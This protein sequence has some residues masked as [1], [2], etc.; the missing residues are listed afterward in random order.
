MRRKRLIRP[1]FG[2]GCVGLIRRDSV[3]SGIDYRMQPT[4]G[5]I[6]QAK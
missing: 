6:S 3:A 2:N 4:R 1:T 5:L